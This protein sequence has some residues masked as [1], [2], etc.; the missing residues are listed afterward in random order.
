MTLPEETNKS[1]IYT[2]PKEIE[3]YELSDKK[4]R[5]I[6]LTKFSEI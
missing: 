5:I 1:P 2:G 6:F 3:I 4:F